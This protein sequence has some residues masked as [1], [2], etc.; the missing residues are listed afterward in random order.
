MQSAES[1]RTLPARSLVAPIQRAL[2]RAL[3][4]A[5]FCGLLGLGSGC[6]NGEFRPGDPFDR[7]ESF[8]RSQHNYTILIRWSDFQKA[9]AYVHPD[10][11]E[12][13]VAEMKAFENARFTD[14]ESEEVD[15]DDEKRTAT[16][17]VT[18]T[19][20]LPSSPFEIEISETQVWSRDGQGNTWLVRPQFGAAPKVAAN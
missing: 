16:V 8:G 17:H 3:N 19:A 15:L 10:D 13:F 12:K 5:L 1:L 18:Y 6:A 2:K 11:R 9:K 20:Y 14:F 4:A 7:A